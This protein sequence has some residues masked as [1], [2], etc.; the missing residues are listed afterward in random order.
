MPVN[1]FI[2]GD[3]Y[4]NDDL[5]TLSCCRLCPRE[6][7]ADRLNG[8][9]GYC[10]TDAGTNIASICIHRGEEPPI[11][12]P[13]GICNIFFSGCNL[14]CSY[15][16]NYEISRTGSDTRPVT[17]SFGESIE[18]IIQI[19][20]KGI[21]AVG[22]VSPSHVVPQLK[23]I[24]KALNNRGFYP[25]TVYNTNGY[26]KRETIQEL[27]GSIDVYLPDFKYFKSQTAKDFS[28]ASDYT[29]IALRALK[30][31]YY[32]KG[33]VLVRDEYGRAE[34]GILVR[35][36]V[37]PGHTGESKKVLSLIAGELSPGI[38]ISLM[39][40]YH[41]TKFVNLHPFLGRRLNQDEYMEVVTEMENLGFRN[42][43]IQDIDSFEN[44][45]PDFRKEHPF[46]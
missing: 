33:S 18:L 27:E 43:W 6:C 2:I 45:L 23:A 25:V 11:S 30:E 37:L 26:D 28:D 17:L 38:N 19:L 4:T 15:C 8:V 14:R 7:G 21:K 31:M 29:E 1:N 39:S 10:N 44:Y 5:K 3:L 16:Q 32:Q 34:K 42:G 13:E 40:Q 36:L 35:H 20:N 9:K 22:F 24:I 41:P 12:G 46:D